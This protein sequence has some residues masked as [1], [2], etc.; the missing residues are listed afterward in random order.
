[1]DFVWQKPVIVFYKERHKELEREPFAVVKARKLVV[2]RVSKEGAKFRGSIE[3]FFPLMGDVDYI[4]S[5]QGMSDRYVLCWFEDEEDDFKKA[6]R[7][8]TGVTFSDGFTFT[9]DEKVKRTYN[10]DFKA[11]QGKLR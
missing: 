2:S 10:G 4:S 8:L 3:D 5:Q 6:W 7:R 1:M 9:T 11:E